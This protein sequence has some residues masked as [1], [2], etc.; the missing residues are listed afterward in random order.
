MLVL[1]F[2]AD[3][4]FRIGSGHIVRNAIGIVKRVKPTHAAALV[5]LVVAAIVMQSA[6]FLGQKCVANERTVFA[7][8]CLLGISCST[9]LV[10]CCNDLCTLR[11]CA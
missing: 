8:V 10:W 5:L 6:E 1:S 4:V 11:S 2:R 3:N 7:F 9:T